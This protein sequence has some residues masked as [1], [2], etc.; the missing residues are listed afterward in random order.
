MAGKSL[1]KYTRLRRGEF[2]YNRGNSKTYP[3]GCVFRLDKWTEAA[4]PNVY[5]SFR[6]VDQNVDSDYVQQFF[7][8]GRLNEQLRKVITSSA[9]ENGLLNITANTFFEQSI[10]CPPLPEQKKIAAILTSVDDDIEKTEGQIQ[11]LEDLKK[12]TT[13]ELLTKGIGHTAFKESAVGRIPKEWEI[14]PLRE[15]CKVRQGL[16]I[17]I[18]QRYDEE[19]ENRLP[20]LTVALLNSGFRRSLIQY[21]ENPNESVILKED[22]FVVGRTGAIGTVFCGMKCVFHN[23]FFA[24][25]I[26]SPKLIKDYLIQ[27]LR[28]SRVQYEMK[29][30]AGTTTIPDLNHGDFY[31]ICI[32]VPSLKEQERVVESLTSIDSTV[33][34]KRRLLGKYKSLKVSLMQDLLT[35]KVRVPL[36]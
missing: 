35:G 3:Q 24:V 6:L 12:A 34:R 13:N 9:R 17:P 16:Q 36:N 28:W 32:V 21:I 4:V 14:L 19:G 18:S 31:S 26:T 2:S 8:A 15:V 10:V 22:E 23:N 33:S 20:Y 25:R 27:Y 29:R 1:D 11:K 30:S 5:H 7:L